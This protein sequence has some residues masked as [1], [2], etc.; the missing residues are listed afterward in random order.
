[1]SIRGTGPVKRK[2]RAKGGF[3]KI[4]DG[5]DRGYLSMDGSSIHCYTSKNSP[6]PWIS[7]LLGDIKSIHIELNALSKSDSAR[8]K[9]APSDDKFDVVVTSSTRDVFHFK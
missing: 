1:M 4:F 8:K 6:N 7:I 5:W 2:L 3:T 9:A